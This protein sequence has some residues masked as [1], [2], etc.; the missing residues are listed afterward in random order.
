MAR[1]MM[2]AATA[3][4][5]AHD[6]PTPEAKARSRGGVAPPRGRTGL[7]SAILAGA[8]EWGTPDAAYSRL[9]R[10]HRQSLFHLLIVGGT[11]GQRARLAFAFHCGSPLRR[12][13]FV[14][15]QG[16][17][18]EARLRRALQCA[19]SAVLCERADNPLRAS[20]GGTLFVDHASLLSLATQRVLLR[21]L[22]SLPMPSGTT[23]ACFGRLAVGSA[24][25]LEAAAAA[26]RF[27]PAQFDNLDK[28]RVDRRTGSRGG[29]AG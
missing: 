20:E 11:A 2:Q 6:T 12:G 5:P 26:G 7:G 19:L 9:I 14:H 8:V 10:Q 15:L 29:G 25:S 28:I 23:R 4:S 3:G 1:G 22:D 16:E 13:P 17:R 27:R 21:F 24:D 18:D